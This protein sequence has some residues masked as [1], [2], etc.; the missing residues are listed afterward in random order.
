MLRKGTHWKLLGAASI[1]MLIGMI[2]WAQGGQGVGGPAG[3]M[4]LGPRLTS[5]QSEAAWKVEAQHVG[6][7]LGLA[8]EAKG[9]LVDAYVQMRKDA[10]KAWEERRAS[11]ERGPDAREDMRKAMQELADSARENL[12]KEVSAFLDEKQTE[13][14]VQRLTGFDARG[15]LMVHVLAGMNLGEKLEEAL[16][17]VTNYAVESRALMRS[18]FEAGAPQEGF[19]EKVMALR[20]KLDEDLSKI[21]SEEQMASWKVAI[22]MGGGM[23]R[24]GGE[25]PRGPQSGGGR[26]E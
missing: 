10:L 21:L 19:R 5:E 17:L 26:T 20:T 3:R 13:T 25:G 24:R 22:G 15:D 6:A 23:G 12:K 8:D 2:A 1:F 14:A 4:G 9:K 11:G 16:E 18:R 7:K